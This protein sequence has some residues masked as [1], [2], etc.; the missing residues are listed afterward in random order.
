MPMVGL[1][2]SSVHTLLCSAHRSDLSLPIL[3]RRAAAALFQHLN[4]S[5]YKRAVALD[6]DIISL[7]NVSF[8][9]ETELASRNHVCFCFL[10]LPEIQTMNL[11]L[12]SGSLL[13]M[14]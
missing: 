9:V 5:F 10:A 12:F 1:Q 14:C 2:L 13:I 8:D 4:H 11:L 6:L 3:L 7:W